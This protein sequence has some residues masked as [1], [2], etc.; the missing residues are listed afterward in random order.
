MLDAV[1]VL[2]AGRLVAYLT[3]EHAI[4]YHQHIGALASSCDAKIV[5]GWKND[6]S[7]GSYGVK[8][9]IK[10]PPRFAKAK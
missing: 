10:W 7:E 6:E 2:I 1:Q 5:G 3:R 9:K 4:E 8:L